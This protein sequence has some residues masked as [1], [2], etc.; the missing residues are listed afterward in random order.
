MLK[1]EYIINIF[2]ILIY[3]VICISIYQNNNIISIKNNYINKISN[4]NIK[5]DI[6]GSIY[7][8]KININNYLYNINSKHN[9]VNENITILYKNNNLIV[10]AAHSGIG[11]LSYFK[12]LNKLT[13]N[14]EIII[15]INN[16]KNKYIV[17][18]KWEEEKNG[19]IN[20]NKTY[21]NELILTTCSPTSNNKQL[22]IESKK[23]D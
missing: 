19:Y 5:K 10:I 12:D 1:K 2:I 16:I 18:N 20:F 23:V 6:I 22:I 8:K 7:I 4:G 13:I 17:I 15:N 9:N 11:R 14:D 21:E 3:I